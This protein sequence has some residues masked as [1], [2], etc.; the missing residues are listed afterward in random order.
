MDGN[1]LNHDNQLTDNGLIN[2][3]NI[4]NL[5]LYSPVTDPDTS[6]D[7]QVREGDELHDMLQLCMLSLT[8]F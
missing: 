6:F 4:E 3:Y 7:T 1:T 5:E 2:I 8:R